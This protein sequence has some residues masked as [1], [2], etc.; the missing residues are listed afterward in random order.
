MIFRIKI[1]GGLCIKMHVKADFHNRKSLFCDS[2]WQW[3]VVRLK[4]KTNWV[5]SVHFNR[6]L[7]QTVRKI[8]A[9]TF[10]IWKKMEWLNFQA[11][12]P[13]IQL[14]SYYI[15]NRKSYSWIE[16]FLGWIVFFIAISVSNKV[17]CSVILLLMI[18]QNV[19][20]HPGC[21][22]SPASLFYL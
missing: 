11:F 4:S 8:F 15:V 22:P 9:L 19:N 5:T 10:L 17:K 6:L 3:D 12:A 20:M 7:G 14:V 21:S 16:C 18:D 2:C 13:I 1:K